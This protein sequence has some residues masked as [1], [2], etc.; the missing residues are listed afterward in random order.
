MSLVEVDREGAMLTVTMN[1]ADK[2][3]ALNSAMIGDLMAVFSQAARNEELQVV[4]L[5]GSGG[6][7]FRPA[8]IW[9]RWPA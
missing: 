3:N 1:R 9:R 6:T 7:A 2:R 4:V 8:P 5:A